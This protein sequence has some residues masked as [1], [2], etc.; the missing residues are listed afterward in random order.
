MCWSRDVESEVVVL[1]EDE[2]DEDWRTSTSMA[3][4]SIVVYCTLIVSPREF[5]NFFMHA[6]KTRGR[7]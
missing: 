5:T 1:L 4:C 6:S 3:T 7:K 2:E